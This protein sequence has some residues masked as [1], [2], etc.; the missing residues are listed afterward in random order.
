MNIV[1]IQETERNTSD[2]ESGEI[3]EEYTSFYSTSIDPKTREKEETRTES[4]EKEQEKD[5][6]RMNKAKETHTSMHQTTNMQ[7][8]QL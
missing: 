2:L 6:E 7:V 4:S 1:M 8:L 3:W 5:G